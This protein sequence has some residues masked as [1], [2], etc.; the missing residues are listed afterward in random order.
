MKTK[1]QGFDWDG[2]QAIAITV[3]GVLLLIGIISIG[4]AQPYFEAQAYN[5]LTG[6]DASY[7]DAAFSQLRIVGREQCPDI[8]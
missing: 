7:F 4:L 2:L 6:G 1:K 5:K 8:Q 3:G